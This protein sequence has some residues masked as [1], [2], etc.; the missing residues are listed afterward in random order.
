V[1]LPLSP[2]TGE[3]V[4]GEDGEPLDSRMGEHLPLRILLVEDHPT[5]QL[6]ATRMLAWLGYRADVAA[7][8]VEALDAL[9]RQPYDVV[10]MDLHLPR[11]DG[12]QAA[13]AIR[14]QATAEHQP[15]IVAFTAAAFEGDRQACLD[16]GMDDFIAK[17]ATRRTLAAALRRAAAARADR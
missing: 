3:L 4:A 16:A 12:K 7:D 8:G 9:V 1:T 5:N 15:T 2:A 14:A 13:R 6:V 10:L 11:L 17:P